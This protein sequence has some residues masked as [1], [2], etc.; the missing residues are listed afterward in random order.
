VGF[1]TVIIDCDLRRPTLHIKFKENN[2]SGISNF[3]TRNANED[4]IIHKTSVDNLSF[5]PAGPLLPN[6]SELLDSGILDDLMDLLKSRFEFI[7][8]DT[9]PVGLVADS[10]QLMKYA[11]QILVVSRNNVTRK[12]IL[13]NALTSLDS[14]KIAN[15]EVI[16]NDLD[17]NKSP[18]SGYKNYYLKE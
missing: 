13:V 7:I 6:P 17:L 14:N 8:I 2:S 18:Y 12:E 5:I 11:N 16:L 10:I 3:M 9:P 1:K 15:Y 4:E